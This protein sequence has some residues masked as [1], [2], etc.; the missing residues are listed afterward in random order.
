MDIWQLTAC[1]RVSRKKCDATQV[2]IPPFV[3]A[4]SLMSTAQ[5]YF[6]MEL[7]TLIAKRAYGVWKESLCV[8]LCRWIAKRSGHR[9]RRRCSKSGGLGVDGV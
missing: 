5:N 4:K 7:G 8:Q 6:R 2:L 9:N 3:S 1:S